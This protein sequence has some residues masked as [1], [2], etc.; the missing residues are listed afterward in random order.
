MTERD[1]DLVLF[2]ATG[3]TGKLVAE[4]LAY[5][6]PSDTRIALAGRSLAKLAAVREAL[7]EAA[8]D[9]QLILADSSDRVS[10]NKLAQSSTAVATTVGPYLTH[11]V[12]L[13]RAC[14]NAG[15]HYLDLAGE[16]LFMRAS[17]DTAH[18]PALASGAKIIHA[19][20]F[21]SIPSDLGVL[22]LHNAAGQLGRTTLLVR[23]MKGGFSGGTMASMR[24]QMEA[25]SE[26][27]SVRGILEDPY[28][29][30]PDRAAEPDFGIQADISRGLHDEE[31]GWLGP[32][33][34]AAT[35]AR[36]V[37][38]SN[39]ISGY[40]YSREFQYREA[41][42]FGEGL[43]ARAKATGVGAGLGAVSA[44]MGFGPT[45][46]GLS[47]VLP[48]PGDGPSAEDRE[49]GH[50]T[51][52]IHTAD[53]EGRRWMSKVAAQGDPGYAATSVMMA[54]AALLTALGDPDL[55][56][57]AGVLT[58]ATALANPLIERL[59]NAGMTLEAGPLDANFSLSN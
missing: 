30:S 12:P 1:L 37:R 41:T 44:A 27:P 29:L 32:F 50:F 9:W 28:S 22:L 10:L 21:D 14:A 15:T 45:R 57:I 2:G 8:R 55:P 58:P 39:A 34:M 24:A 5:R 26:D 54:E 51:M 53:L 3:F 42:P 49:S 31:L 47:K 48:R 17:V 59:R 25:L 46:A 40:R 18:G 16:V 11:G 35:N 52:E 23:E 20:G 4:Q 19:C 56:D 33:V 13:V 36:V 6:A 38:R 43:T 7:P